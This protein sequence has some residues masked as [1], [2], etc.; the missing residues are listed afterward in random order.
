MF[1]EGKRMTRR[2]RFSIRVRPQSGYEKLFDWGM[3]PLMYFLSGTLEE[4]PQRT[5]FWNNRKLHPGEVV[6]LK[7][8]D[9]VIASGSGCVER[10]KYGFPIFHAP[11]L[12]GWNEYIVLE[13]SINPSQSWYVGWISND[14][15]SGVS[16]VQIKGSVRL[17]LGNGST[18][19]FGL[20]VGGVQI[21]IHEMGRG[22][23]GDGGPFSQLPLL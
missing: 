11:I 20:N 16:R 5:H 7:E 17:L 13:P 19:F 21:K 2:R 3:T 12:G 14:E 6:G 9:V 8:R 23:I 10:W 18:K 1:S 15:V 4:I 22:R